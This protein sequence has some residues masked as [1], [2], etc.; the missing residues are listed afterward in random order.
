VLLLQA[1]A[2]RARTT[3]EA[4]DRAHRVSRFKA[5]RPPEKFEGKNSSTRVAITFRVCP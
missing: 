1:E 2:A 4:G 3:S 5:M